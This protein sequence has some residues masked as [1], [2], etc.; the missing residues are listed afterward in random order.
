[1]LV[2]SQKVTFS[3]D[4][5]GFYA[6]TK[7]YYKNVYFGR[8]IFNYEGLLEFHEKNETPFHKYN[9]DDKQFNDPQAIKEY[10]I[11]RIL[12]H[13]KRKKEDMNWNFERLTD[14][15]KEFFRLFKKNNLIKR[16][17]LEN[18]YKSSADF[19]VIEGLLE[20]GTLDSDVVYYTKNKG[21][22]LVKTL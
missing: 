4:S 10:V 15:S 11:K 3:H 9:I 1:M 14:H 20:K 2:K 18:K 8:I 6:V 5:I 22:E 7:V 16:K 13:E 17:D 21:S 12:K 19:F